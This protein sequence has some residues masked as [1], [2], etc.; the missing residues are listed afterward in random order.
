MKYS[1]AKLLFELFDGDKERVM[2]ALRSI[3]N[4]TVTLDELESNDYIY[5]SINYYS[6]NDYVQVYNGTIY[7]RDDTMWCEDVKSTTMLTIW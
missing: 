3:K 2:L 7:H 5:D 1:E 6:S 4:G